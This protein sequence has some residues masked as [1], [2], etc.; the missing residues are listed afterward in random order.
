M[1]ESPNLSL[2]IFRLLEISNLKYFSYKRNYEYMTWYICLSIKRTTFI[3][4]LLILLFAKYFNIPF[5]ST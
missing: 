3:L 2:L 1:L 4:I 5:L